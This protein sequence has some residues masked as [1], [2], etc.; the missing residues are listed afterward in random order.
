MAA[1]TGTTGPRKKTGDFVARRVE[2]SFE[3]QTDSEGEGVPGVNEGDFMISITLPPNGQLSRLHCCWQL[4]HLLRGYE[5]TVKQ[6]L[7]QSEDLVTFILELKTILEVGLKSFPE[8]RSIPPPQY[9]S[10]LISEMET[11]GWS[12]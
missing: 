7:Q 10:Q 5:Q 9:Y 12:K 3:L 6:R 2:E 4:K 1:T 11:L 8:R